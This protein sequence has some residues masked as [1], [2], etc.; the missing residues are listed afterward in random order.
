MS[1]VGVS[2]SNQEGTCPVGGKV[3]FVF[4]LSDPGCKYSGCCMF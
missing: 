2:S 3:L 1:K 4:E